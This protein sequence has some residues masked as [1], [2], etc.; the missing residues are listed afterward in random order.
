MSLFRRAIAEWNKHFLPGVL[1]S[2]PAILAVFVIPSLSRSFAFP[3][4][5][6]FRLLMLCL[7]LGIFLFSLWRGR[8]ELHLERFKH[9]LVLL[10]AAFLLWMSVATF[11]SPSFL[12]GLWGSHERGMGLIPFFFFAGYFSLLLLVLKKEYLEQGMK[13]AF[14]SGGLIGLYA[15]LQKLGVDP[16][17]GNHNLDFLEGRSF[18]T[19]GNPDFMAQF[20][21]PLWVASLIF[22]SKKRKA[23]VL[24][25][26]ILMLAGMIVS[27]SRA[28]FLAA[29]SAISLYVLLKQGVKKRVVFG[30][31][32]VVLLVLLGIVLELPLFER[33]SINTVNLRSLFSRFMLWDMAGRAIFDHALLG[34]GPDSFSIHFAEYLKPAFYTLEENLHITG[35]RAHNET[36]DIALVGGIPLMLL[37]LAS[38]ACI[39][40]QLWKDSKV[41]LYSFPILVIFL[42]NQLSFPQFSHLVLLMF[43]MAAVV[44]SQASSVKTQISFTRPFRFAA[45]VFSVLLTVFLI[46]ES[47]LYPL[48]AE[49]WFA[50]ARST[51]D[52]NEALHTAIHFAPL[53]THYRY[54][55]VMWFPEERESQLNQLQAIEGDNINLLAWMANDQVGK[56]PE[57]AYA[58]FEELLDLNPQYPHTVRAYA[59]GLYVNGEFEGAAEY[60]ERYF[61]LVPEFWTWCLDLEER[62]AHEQKQYRVFYKNVPDFNNSIWQLWKSYDAL[63]DAAALDSWREQKECHS[64]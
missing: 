45:P 39:F 50:Y 47:V 21:A 1:I 59:D 26:S 46:L 15:L 19:L 4:A 3:K 58:L 35:D 52:A 24:V 49:A 32:F 38:Y 12:H 48:S 40:K 44:I 61:D 13:I 29:F 6:I 5:L 57:T 54:A 18:A 23:W 56:D 2:M 17:F 42:Q 11:A 14:V 64:T 43:L 53:N 51:S 31:V 22:L 27:E 55:M 20:L 30:A 37:Y 25:M 33:L 28:S 34:L 7:V 41:A 9:P 62:S 10:L 63:G 16:L 8:I 36:L 60:Y